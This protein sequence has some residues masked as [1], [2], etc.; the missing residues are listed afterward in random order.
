MVLGVVVVVDDVD[1]DANVNGDEYRTFTVG[2]CQHAIT[3]TF[4]TLIII[5]IFTFVYR[6]HH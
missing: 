5:I 4:D 6:F 1:V 3:K 2:G